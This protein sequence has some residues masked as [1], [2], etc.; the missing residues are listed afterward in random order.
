MAENRD[1]SVA[2]VGA[3]GIVGNQLIELIGARGIALGELKLFATESGAAGTVSGV[4]EESLVEVLT[5]PEDLRGFDI[6]FL[7]LPAP[8]AA[9]IVAANPGP[10]LI[11]LSAATQQPS[12]VALFAPGLTPRAQIEAR[13]SETVFAVPHPVA[14]TLAICLSAVGSLARSIGATAM[15]GASG[16]GKLGIEATVKQTTDLLGAQ[17]DLE[18]EETQ[19]GF[20]IFMR[21]SE[22]ALAAAISAQTAALCSGA[23]LIALQIVAVPVLHGTGLTIEIPSEGDGDALIEHLRAAPGLLVQEA[24]EPLAVIDAVGQEA[25]IVSVD[26]VPGGIAIWCVF[27]NARLAALDALWIAESLAL[28]PA[29][30]A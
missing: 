1:P 30:L 26:R 15:I 6:V 18:D 8:R 12:E 23:P 27:D 21:E 14:H 24:G 25:I 22:R 11:D 2:I 19:R 29:T 3:T 5:S 17:L 20:N 13:R 10:K 28:N 4:G 16:A 9:E 7:A